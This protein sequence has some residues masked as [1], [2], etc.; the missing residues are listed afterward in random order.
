MNKGNNSKAVIAFV[1]ILSHYIVK[2][3]LK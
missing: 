3:L 1:N 2:T